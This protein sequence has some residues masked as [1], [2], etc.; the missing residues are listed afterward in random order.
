MM[1]YRYKFSV[2]KMSKVLRVS[3][4]GFYKWLSRRDEVDRHEEQL[5]TALLH[6]DFGQSL[7]SYSI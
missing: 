2:E 5:N 4:S 1:E 6:E 7:R 3:R